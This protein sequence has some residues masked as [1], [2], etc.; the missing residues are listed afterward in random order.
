[1]LSPPTI[2]AARKAIGTGPPL[3]L[4]VIFG[5]VARGTA[6]ADSDVDIGIVP[7]DIDLSLHDETRLQLS[8][9][10]ALGRPVDLVRLDRASSLL[11]GECARDGKLLFEAKPGDFV[12]FRAR[13]TGEWLEF[14]PAYR[15]AA[16]RFRQR[17]IQIGRS[18]Q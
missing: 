8:L 17:L 9:E 3:R 1:M 4:A 18:A 11:L 14:A 13:A 5:S 6:R 16:E 12:I 10:A 2:T 15:R 7:V